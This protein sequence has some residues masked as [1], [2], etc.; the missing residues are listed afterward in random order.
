M[1]QSWS[2]IGLDVKRYDPIV[3]APEE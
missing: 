1:Q 3:E 2:L